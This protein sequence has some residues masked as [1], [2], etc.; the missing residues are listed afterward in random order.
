MM[1]NNLNVIFFILKIFFE[2]KC[3]FVLVELLDRQVPMIDQ[4]LEFGNV[5]PAPRD[6][7]FARRRNMNRCKYYITLEVK[8]RQ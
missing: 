6:P 2:L 4:P 7:S 8:G 3:Y 5:V 1:S